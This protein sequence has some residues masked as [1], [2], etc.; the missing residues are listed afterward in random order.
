MLNLPA[1]LSPAYASKHMRITDKIGVTH[2]G[3]MNKTGILV[4]GGNKLFFT[5]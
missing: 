1:P 3:G 2:S 5:G 4:W